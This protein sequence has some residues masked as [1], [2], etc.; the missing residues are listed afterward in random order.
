MGYSLSLRKGPAIQR[1]WRKGL[2]IVPWGKWKHQG[3]IRS[4]WKALQGHN[5]CNTSSYVKLVTCIQMAY[6]SEDA[7]H[8]TQEWYRPRHLFIHRIRKFCSNEQH[9]TASPGKRE[10][11]KKHNTPHGTK[12][13]PKF[14]ASLLLNH[15]DMQYSYWD[16]L[17][18][19]LLTHCTGFI[20]SE[21]LW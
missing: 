4:S 10:M 14:P 9:S 17:D 1:H 3:A 13:F 20:I 11:E 15:F 18:H 7:G 8:H 21:Q 16:N 2:R 19:M 6:F 5:E 12:T